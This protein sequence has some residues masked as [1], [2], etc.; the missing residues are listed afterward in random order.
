MRGAFINLGFM[1]APL[2]NFLH[3]AYRAAGRYGR[4]C[5]SRQRNGLRI[6]GTSVS[7]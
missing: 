1:K 2:I 6:G 3:R 4:T 5:S 7:R